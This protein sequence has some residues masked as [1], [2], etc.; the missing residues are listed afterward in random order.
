MLQ[1]KIGMT[2]RKSLHFWENL[3]KDKKGDINTLQGDNWSQSFL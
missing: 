2:V 3:V 1:V